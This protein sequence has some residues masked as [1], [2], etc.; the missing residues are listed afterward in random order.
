MVIFSSA[1]IFED[2]MLADYGN[3]YLLVDTIGSLVGEIET[4]AVRPRYLYPKPLNI[5]QKPVIIWPH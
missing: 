5:T 3:I 2:N 4:I 1:E